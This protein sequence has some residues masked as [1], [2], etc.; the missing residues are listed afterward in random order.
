MPLDE[1][2]GG[3]RSRLQPIR[4]RAVAICL[5]HAYA[6]DRHERRVRDLLRPLLPGVAISPVERGRAEI[7]EYER[8]ST[9]VAN[10]YVQPLMAGYLQRLASEPMREAASMARSS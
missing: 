4:S 1:G 6:H 10:A 3:D 2:G 9:T 5:L 7:R 8:F